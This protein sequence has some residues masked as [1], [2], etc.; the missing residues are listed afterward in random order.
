[1]GGGIYGPQ[2]DWDPMSNEFGNMFLGGGLSRFGPRGLPGGKVKPPSQR[3][4]LKYQGPRRGG[5]TPSARRK[6]VLPPSRL[7]SARKSGRAAAFDVS[8]K[9]EDQA[10]MGELRGWRQEAGMDAMRLHLDRYT[11]NQSSSWLEYM[12]NRSQLGL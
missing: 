8:L 10:F 9:W 3:P 12:K 5:V 2:K 11:R 7:E 1:M 4:K 6:L